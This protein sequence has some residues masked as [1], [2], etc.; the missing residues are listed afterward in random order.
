[1]SSPPRPIASLAPEA[2]AAHRAA[3]WRYLRTLGADAAT[4]DDLVQEAFVVALRRRDVDAASPAHAFAFLRTTARHLWLKSRRL[5]VAE[6]EVEDADRVWDERCGDGTGDD[7]VA[8]LRAC[9]ADLPERSRALLEATYGERR[10]RGASAQALGMSADGIKSAL[11]RLRA[12]LHDCIAR[13]QRLE[14]RRLEER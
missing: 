6:R 7:Y 4:A 14:E 5:K 2:L 10:G 8:A 13:R 3:L 12:F 9:L 11:R 1:V